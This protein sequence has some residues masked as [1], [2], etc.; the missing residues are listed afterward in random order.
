ML[1]IGAGF[2]RTGTLSFKA[3]LEIL[4][5]GPCHHM[6]DGNTIDMIKG[7]TEPH[8]LDAL[9]IKPFLV[10]KNNQFGDFIALNEAKSHAEQDK[11]LK[12]FTIF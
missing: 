4:G 9:F 7:R 5:F 12:V 11:I 1:V 3:A 2:G 10:A 8:R 6:I